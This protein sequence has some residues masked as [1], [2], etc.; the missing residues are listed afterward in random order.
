MKSLL[1]LF[2]TSTYLSFFSPKYAVHDVPVELLTDAKIVIRDHS[3][4]IKVER[5]DRMIIKESLVKTIL[6]NDHSNEINL[7]FFHDPSVKIKDLKA[8]IYNVNGE[9]IEELNKRKFNDYS[10]TSGSTLYSDSRALN[11]TYNSPS[12]PITVAYDITYISSS[13]GFIRQW[14][15]I[16]AYN[17]SLESSSYH[18]EYDPSLGMRSKEHN[19]EDFAQIETAISDNSI[20]YTARNIPATNYE[21]KAPSWKNI[22]PRVSSAFEN[23]LLKNVKGVNKNWATIGAWMYHSL[24]KNQGV[25]NNGVKKDI[26]ELILNLSS[27]EEKARAIYHYVQNRS[28]YISVQLD[29][30]GWKP[31]AAQSVHDSG[32]G[33]CK[34]LTNYT[35]ALLKYAGITS[36][37]SVIYGGDKLNNIDPELSRIEG[38]HVILCIPDLVNQDTTWLECTSQS[39]P[40][41]YIA[42]FTDDRLALILT[43]EGGKVRKT[44]AYGDYEN[45]STNHNRIVITSSGDISIDHISKKSGALFDHYQLLDYYDND[46]ADYYRQYWDNIPRF[47]LNS[48]SYNVDKRKIELVENVHAT[49]Q[50][51]VQNTDGDIILNVLTLKH[52]IKSPPRIRNRKLPI[53]I[54]RGKEIIDT[55]TLVLPD[56]Y[57]LKYSPE[58]VDIQT[59]FGSYSLEVIK[60][61]DNELSVIRKLILKKGNFPARDYNSY[62]S[63]YKK[64]NKQDQSKLLLTS[65]T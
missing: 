14:I 61:S 54:P 55:T 16:P 17:V 52:P 7:S 6:D 32:Y 45:T 50:Q 60:A 23:F 25:I 46:M 19:L 62:R 26:D 30:G 3:L 29:I 56:N 13:T 27:D 40:F 31:I 39:S 20:K 38:N 64:I 1:I 35:M 49:I 51:L 58:P 2:I 15:P 43:P 47:Q 48:S 10:T 53:I 33:D 8:I 12:F 59:P 22:A 5:I 11:Y 42:N 37:Y 57:R 44:K 34:G 41:G 4:H 24:V 63:F 65:K 18:I 21:Y 28:R 36:Y 9:V